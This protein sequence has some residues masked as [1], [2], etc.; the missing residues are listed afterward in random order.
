MMRDDN[1]LAIRP[2]TIRGHDEFEHKC[3]VHLNL[4]SR[5]RLTGINQLW[6]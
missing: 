5:M 6:G 3:E 2:K 1:L 4:A